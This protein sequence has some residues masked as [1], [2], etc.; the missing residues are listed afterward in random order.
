MKKH[1]LF[2]TFL[3]IA[4]CV[5]CLALF[6]TEAKAASVDDLTFWLN[7]DGQ[8]YT[9]SG[10]DTSASGELEIPATYNGKPVTSIGEKAFFCFSSLT[11]IT[12]PDSVTSIGEDAF[13]DCS[14]TSIAIPDSV[15]SIGDHAF[16]SCGSLA[17]VTIPD[18]VT[19]IP[20]WYSGGVFLRWT[21]D[22]RP[23][24]LY[25]TGNHI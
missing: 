8:S 20:R 22:F 11:S 12:I 5:I 17:S 10:C 24:T 21:L 9:V 6:P 4:L 15:T 18:S 16:F 1:W 3:A 19:C 13:R 7:R 14:L 23:I 25:N 2:T